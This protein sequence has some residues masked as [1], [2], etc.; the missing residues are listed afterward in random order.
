MLH[1]L[2]VVV[3]IH[4][5]LNTVVHVIFPAVIVIVVYVTVF[6]SPHVIAIGILE[7]IHVLI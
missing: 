5:I 1:H 3:K 4:Q 6:F 2:V 7:P